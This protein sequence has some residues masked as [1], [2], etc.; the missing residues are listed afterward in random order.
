MAK[1]CGNTDR[2]VDIVHPLH[3]SISTLAGHDQQTPS[4][5]NHP[6]D[7]F[8]R[9]FSFHTSSSS[10]INSLLSC[11]TSSVSPTIDHTFSPRTSCSL[12]Q[13]HTPSNAIPPTAE[14]PSPLMLP[15]SPSVYPNTTMTVQQDNEPGGVPS[16][17][18]TSEGDRGQIHR[19]IRDHGG[20]G[21]PPS[22]LGMAFTT[23]V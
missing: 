18:R 20:C 1:S 23:V 13:T 11:L 17:L 9:E 10:C 4:S 12:S 5:S 8:I 22:L 6:P 2:T 7:I 3:E 19:E 16:C 21:I 15:T 14:V